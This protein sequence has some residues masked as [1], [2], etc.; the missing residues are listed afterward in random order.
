MKSGEE[1]AMKNHLFAILLVVSIL[2][3]LQG[4]LYRAERTQGNIIEK[5]LVDKITIGSNK[6]QV[7]SLL[8]YPLLYHPFNAN[9]WI[10]VYQ[11]R[12]RDGT[13]FRKHLV[14]HFDSQDN[15]SQLEKHNI[16][17]E[18]IPQN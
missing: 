4:C 3:S 16:Q 12:Q 10:Y 9:E 15:V 17:A 18:P 2:L 13:F 8:G 1:K 6:Q 7:Q 5:A 14:V 11:L